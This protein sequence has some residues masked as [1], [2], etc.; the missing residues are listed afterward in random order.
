[1][2]P[3]PRLFWPEVWQPLYPKNFWSVP[4]EDGHDQC[5]LCLGSQHALLARENPESCVLYSQ[6]RLERPMLVF[7]PLNVPPLPLLMFLSP[8]WGKWLPLKCRQSM[9]ARGQ[10]SLPCLLI[11]Q[12]RP[13]VVPPMAPPQG[14]VQWRMT[15][16]RRTLMS[17]PSSP[18]ATLT[19]P[20]DSPQLAP[21]AWC[22]ARWGSSRS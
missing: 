8:K 7:L 5:I 17:S 22:Q 2:P 3:P 15:I 6:H 18:L 11:C 10:I 19:C 1:M 4:L 12:G 16:R 21:Q 9:Q 13:I 20:L 14:L